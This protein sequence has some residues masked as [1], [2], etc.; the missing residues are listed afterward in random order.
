[1]K[2][3]QM[4][5]SEMRETECQTGLFVINSRIADHIYDVFNINIFSSQPR[6][7]I[8]QSLYSI[9]AI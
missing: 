1:V 7:H 5:L 2:K 3:Q 9:T 6:Q 4:A 8:E